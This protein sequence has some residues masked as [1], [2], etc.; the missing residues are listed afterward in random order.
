IF[1]SKSPPQRIQSPFMSDAP[2]NSD[3]H[4]D[5]SAHP[6]YVIPRGR[7]QGGEC[8][9][10][11]DLILSLLS[12]S[13]IGAIEILGG[14]GSGK[15]TALHHVAHRLSDHQHLLL[16]DHPTSD[17]LM[18]VSKESILIFTGLPNASEFLTVSLARIHLEPW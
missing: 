15:S 7:I 18:H 6:A 11:H 16:L 12:R 3:T 14:E 17:E 10:V 9:P 13:S 8:L 1:F 4:D 2:I 5:H